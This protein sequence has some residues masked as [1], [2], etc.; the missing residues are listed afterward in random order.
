VGKRTLPDGP[1]EV[2]LRAE[3]EKTEVALDGAAHA[4]RALWQDLQSA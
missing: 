3:R 1:L 4:I 2:Q